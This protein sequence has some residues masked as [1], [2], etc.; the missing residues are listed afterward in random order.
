MDMESGRRDKKLFNESW[1]L[2]LHLV[3]NFP[4][5]IKLRKVKG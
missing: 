5:V 1:S 3:I 4:F 2:H